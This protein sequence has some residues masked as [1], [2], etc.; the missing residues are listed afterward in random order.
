MLINHTECTV[1][2]KAEEKLH[3][4]VGKICRE[5]RKLTIFLYGLKCKMIFFLKKGWITYIYSFYVYK[6]FNFDI[7]S[8]SF[9]LCFK[10]W[11]FQSRTLFMEFLKLSCEIHLY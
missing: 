10:K 9:I 11:G 6:I 4:F 5:P 1:S 8:I 2:K 3:F 7:I